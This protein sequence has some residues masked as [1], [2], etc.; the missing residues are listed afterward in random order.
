MPRGTETLLL[1][2]D[3]PSVRHLAS[4]V[5]QAQGYNVLRANNGEDG[6]RVAREYKQPL[7]LVIT[8]VMMPHMGGKEMAEALQAIHPSVK[9]LFTS[10]YT[11]EK[12]ARVGVGANCFIPKPYH[13]AQLTD[14]IRSVLDGTIP[15][16]WRTESVVPISMSAGPPSS[17]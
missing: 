11:D 12:L 8:D 10:G 4:N 7:P 9:V 6:L 1:V 13:P 3:E 14:A 5:L 16:R 2:E 17:A 15:S